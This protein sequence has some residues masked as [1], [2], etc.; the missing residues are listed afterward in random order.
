MNQT[1]IGMLLILSPVFAAIQTWETPQGVKV[2]YTQATE[3]P[4]VDIAVVS[5][6]GSRYAPAGLAKLT[7][8]SLILGSRHHNK[9]QLNALL[10]T[11]GSLFETWVTRN[12]M[13][14][15]FRGLSSTPIAEQSSLLAEII[16]S[17][18]F[19]ENELKKQIEEQ[20]SEI[21]HDATLPYAVANNELL[22]L[23]Y[24]GSPGYSAPINGEIT[25]I[26]QYTSLDL[27]KFHQKTFFAKNL[28]IIIIGDLPL[29][30]AKKAA[31]II[32]HQIPNNKEAPLADKQLSEVNHPASKA[33]PFPGKQTTFIMANKNTLSLQDPDYAAF[34]VLID[35]LGGGSYAELYQDLRNNKGLVYGVFSSFS[36]NDHFSTLSILGQTNKENLNKVEQSTLLLLKKIA[37]HGPDK[38]IFQI[39]KNSAYN[40]QKL[41]ASNNTRKLHRIINIVALG[42]PI[43]FD[44]S[45][46][47]AIGRVTYDDIKRLSGKLGNLEF[48]RV[49]VGIQIKPS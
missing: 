47:K 10:A 46:L 7:V 42:L 8:N 24:K 19:P 29:N 31:N 16:A 39:A 15:H 13:V 27:N 33:I 5:N 44:E 4:M 1:A 41:I 45:Y 17:P 28:S 11:N 2:Y 49:Y 9:N 20:V 26:R 37:T 48:Y 21:K 34:S 35:L 38:K 32:S 3:I 23:L 36:P 30:E 6:A 12:I 22:K 25:S 18:A 40:E 14:T 43:D